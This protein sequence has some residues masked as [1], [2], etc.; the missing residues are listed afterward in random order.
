[1]SVSE[2]QVSEILRDMSVRYHE[3]FCVEPGGI[4]YTKKKFIDIM[5]EDR[6]Y[7]SGYTMFYI[8]LDEKNNYV[9]CGT[10]AVN[11]FEPKKFVDVDKIMY[12][13]SY[14]RESGDRHMKNFKQNFKRAIQ[15]YPKQKN[16]QERSDDFYKTFGTYMTTRRRRKLEDLQR[17]GLLSTPGL[18][19][20]HIGSALTTGRQEGLF[21]H[22][23]G[24]CH[25][26][27][28]I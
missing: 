25:N 10:M 9:G 19:H 6:I 14:F 27:G 28:I 20:P 11:N 3:D 22:P 23:V 21:F 1:M 24:T 16:K 5:A 18:V 2:Q 17:K 26:L 8:I 12:G 15:K 4:I 13:I 7:Y